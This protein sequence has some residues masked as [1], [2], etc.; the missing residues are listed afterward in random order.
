[1]VC[2]RSSSSSNSLLLEPCSGVTSNDCWSLSFPC[3]A[4]LGSLL[5]SDFSSLFPSSFNNIFSL[6]KLASALVLDSSFFVE[7]INFLNDPNTELLL[8]TLFMSDFASSSSSSINNILSLAKLASALVLNSSFFLEGIIFLNDPITD[9]LL[10]VKLFM[11]ETSSSSLATLSSNFLIWASTS[12]ALVFLLECL[13]L[14]TFCGEDGYSRPI[15]FS[16]VLGIDL[17]NIEVPSFLD[18]SPD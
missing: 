17:I 12:P 4:I 5:A 6:A 10:L 7:A 16:L 11:S 13:T 1:M 15:S 3:I 18:S 9:E 2:I 14:E 8:D